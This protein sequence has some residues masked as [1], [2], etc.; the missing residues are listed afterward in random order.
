[1]IKK[2]FGMV[3]SLFVKKVEAEE[4]LEVNVEEE[5]PE[6]KVVR[7]VDFATRMRQLS[8]SLNAPVASEPVRKV[9]VQP[10]KPKVTWEQF[11]S[12]NLQVNSYLNSRT[13]SEVA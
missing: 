10:Q 5:I 11:K 4:V 9:P 2:L 1:M 13:H 6:V 12:Y 8:Q 7:S 3:K